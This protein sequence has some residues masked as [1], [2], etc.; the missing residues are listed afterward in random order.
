MRHYLDPGSGSCRRVSAVAHYLSIEL[1]EVFVD[2]LQGAHRTPDYMKLNPGGMVPTLIDGDLTLTEADVIMI[3]LAE[4]VRETALWPHGPARREV[5]RWMAWAAEH[6]RQGPPMLVEELYLK[7]FMNAPA[8]A[9]RVAEGRRRI[10]RFAPR[11]DA[12]LNG[13]DYVAGSGPTLADFSL[14]AP[15]SHMARA[16]LPFEPYPNILAWN[17]RLNEIPA[18][19]DTGVRLRERM[20]Q[21]EAAAGLQFD[22]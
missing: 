3:H 8:D 7:R 22:G 18:W 20:A 13:R 17:A 1:E 10:E 15:L 14:A 11:L 16:Q 4:S 5:Q 19:R 2:L 9:A 21:A 6:F 12:H